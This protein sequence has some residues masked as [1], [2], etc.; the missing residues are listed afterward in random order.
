MCRLKVSRFN[1]SA[2]A[3]NSLVITLPEYKCKGCHSAKVV[4]ERRQWLTLFMRRTKLDQLIIVV[5][6]FLL[7]A[8]GAGGAD[9]SGTTN[10]AVGQTSIVAPTLSPLL[11]NS[12]GETIASRRGWLKQR[13]VIRQN[14]LNFMG[15]F[16]GRKCPLKL[17]VLDTEDLPEFT[18]RHISYQVEE[19]VFTDGYLLVPK[20]PKG[21]LPA[22]VVF[23]STVKEQAKL[24]AGIN[25]TVPEK[26]QGLQLVQRGYIVLC[27]RNF[28]Y[29]EGAD[30][31]GNVARLKERHSHWTGMGKMVFDGIRAVDV[32]ESLLEVDRKHIGVMG[33][34]LGGKEALYAAAFDER[35]K[36]A[37]SSEGGIGL[38]FSNWDADWY[39]GPGINSPDFKHENHEILALVA[40]RAFLL[41]AGGSADNDKSGV[42]IQ[43]AQPIYRLFN[44]EEKLAWFNHGL[45]HRY[46]P[47]ARNVAEDFLDRYL[48]GKNE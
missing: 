43:A 24:V 45:G 1:D 20:S 26:A 18:R 7:N 4:L 21:K 41:L 19:G 38:R 17:S 32:L 44:A 28:I 16:P 39:L 6:L 47:E 36:A 14:W 5:W 30:F 23:H 27:P 42:F 3:F 11:L 8:G 25:Q 46:P 37:V 9:I 40:P 2:A 34:S 29:N 22:V 10:K 31:G 48:K 13:E 33:H 15:E 12:N 35:I